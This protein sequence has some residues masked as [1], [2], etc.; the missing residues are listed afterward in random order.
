MR[1]WGRNWHDEMALT[2]EEREKY[3]QQLSEA[4]ATYH[5]LMM[6][7]MAAEFTDQNGERIRYSSANRGDLLKYI[8]YLRSLLG[9][10]PFG[11]SVGP[12]MG[13]IL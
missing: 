7:G 9:L 4:E 6:G 2:D 1:N 10:C 12:P 11:H 3:K 5:R 8:N 13:V